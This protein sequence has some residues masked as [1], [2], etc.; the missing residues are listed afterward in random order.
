MSNIWHCTSADAY[1]LKILSELLSNNIKIANFILNKKGLFLTMTDHHKYISIDMSLDHDKFSRWEL[2]IPE[3]E[4]LYVGINMG[5]L[6]KMLKSIKKKDS[7]DLFITKENPMELSI[8][9]TPKDGARNTVSTIKIQNTQHLK[10]D[11]PSNYKKS[12]L[13][14]SSGYQKSMKDLAD[15][16]TSKVKITA[17]KFYMCMEVNAGEIMK[18]KAEFGIESKSDPIEYE[19]TFSFEHLTKISKI[20]GLNTNMQIY[21]NTNSIPL[22]FKSMIKNLGN[23]SIY[24]KSDEQIEKDKREQNSSES[25][26]E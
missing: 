2:N 11:L 1:E 4:N 7:V 21:Y 3:N 13:L 22:C 5:Q 14:S 23:I 18:K 6:F 19:Q 24:I 8:R 25:D 12:I 9:V 26:S 16:N 20:A 10:I 15:V 17:K